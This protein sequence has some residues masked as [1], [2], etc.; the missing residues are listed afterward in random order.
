MSRGNRNQRFAPRTF[1]RGNDFEAPAA[2]GRDGL[3]RVGFAA[4]DCDG[5]YFL[6]A[7][8]RP[9]GFDGAALPVKGTAEEFCRY[10][11]TE[12]GVAAIPVSAFYTSEGPDNGASDYLVRFC[13]CKQDAVLEEAISRLA[14]HFSNTA[15]KG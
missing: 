4:A 10:I 9:L 6:N 5:T 12:V 3:E 1:D 2:V 7:D 8:F 15:S 11:T 13:F 14:R